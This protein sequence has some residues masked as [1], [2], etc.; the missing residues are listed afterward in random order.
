MAKEVIL[1][2]NNIKVVDKKRSNL[3]I[4]TNNQKNQSNNIK[5]RKK[6]HNSSQPGG[7]GYLQFVTLK[8]LFID[9]VVQLGDLGSDFAQGYTLIINEELFLY[10]IATF[11]IHWVP[12]IVAAIHCVSTK[13][14]EYGVRQTLT[15]AGIQYI[16]FTL[17]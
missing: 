16:T 11:A 15:W 8:T 12:G 13:R 17:E 4:K 5:L 6:R 3:N 2:V 10:G 9:L 1:D 7:C 14:E